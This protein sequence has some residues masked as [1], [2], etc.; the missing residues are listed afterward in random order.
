MKKTFEM[1]LSVALVSGLAISAEI[2]PG[3]D[4]RNDAVYAA[5]RMVYDI[6]EADTVPVNDVRYHHLGYES[7]LKTAFFLK[8]KSNVTLDFK[9]ATILLHGKFQPFLIDGCTNVTVKNVTVKYARSPFTEGEVVVKDQDVLKLKVDK[10]LFPYEVRDGDCYFRGEGVPAHPSLSS[11]FV[12][13]YDAKTRE[14]HFTRLVTLGLHA[15]ID[16]NAPWAKNVRVLEASEENGLLVFRT[17]KSFADWPVH[18]G[19]RM[20]MAHEGRSFSNCMM[21]ES[22]DLHLVNYRILNGYGMGIFPFHCHNL[23][24]EGLRLTQDAESPSIVAN[25]ADGIHAF[26]CS[27]DFVVRD[28]IIEGTIDDALNVHAN[29][30]KVKSVV[31]NRIIADTG[32]EPYSTTAL[33]LPCDRIRVY[34]GYTLDPAA[35]YTIVATRPIDKK[36]VEFT[37]DR[38]ALA[39]QELDAIENLSTQCRLTLSNCRFGRSTAHLRFQTRGGVLVENCESALQFMLS[40]DMSY[41]FESSPCEKAV[42]RNVRFKGPRGNFW[43]NPQFVPSEKAPYY[44][45]DL[46]LENCTFE[47]EKAVGAYYV[48]SVTL[49]NCTRADGGK[50]QIE[51]V[52]CGTVSAPGCD[53]KARTEK[54]QPLRA[55]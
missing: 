29:Y 21:V 9:G 35:E 3:A 33:F 18:V 47:A 8:G 27:G 30:F 36:T 10:T 39:H 50:P 19:D 14:N 1:L 13:F 12:K 25:L 28:S 2:K 26:A 51:L 40:G 15:K 7:T 16:P 42:F 37:V 5:D 41:W 54:P 6:H 49:K 53:V 32:L 52:N 4:W 31:G 11:S 45:G 38:P 34:R 22:R 44:H 46:I 23:K 48:K 43:I 55:N 24:I 17:A 20:V